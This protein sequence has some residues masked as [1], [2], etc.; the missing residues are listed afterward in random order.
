MLGADEFGFATAPLIAIGCL[1]MRKCHLNTCPVGIATQNPTLRKRFIGTPEHAINYLFF[2]AEEVRK[3]MAKLGFTKFNELIGKSQC[4]TQ[5]NKHNGLSLKPLLARAIP[6]KDDAT[7]NCTR[8]NHPIEKVLDRKLIRE[9]QPALK[10]KKRVNITT[11]ISNID[12]STGAMLSGEL[13]KIHNHKGLPADTINVELR[14]TAGQSFGA[15]LANGITFRLTGEGNDYVGKGL[16]GG[17]II[18]APESDFRPRHQNVIVGN[19]VLYGA[20]EGELYA[21]GLA[22]ERFAVRNSGAIAVVEGVGDHCCEYMT[23]GIV[24]AM[25]EYGRNFAAGMSGGIAY[26]Y[27]PQNTSRNTSKDTS[28]NKGFPISKVV[29]V[30]P[31][32]SF[33]EPQHKPQNEPEYKGLT[34]E[35]L[36]Y[37]DLTY[38]PLN[39]HQWRVKT[40]LQR[41]HYFTASPLAKELLENW[42]NTKNDFVVLTPPEFR[43]ALLSKN[44]NKNLKKS[45]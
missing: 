26:V 8:Q 28:Q 34:Y 35:D 27:K 31:L 45:A 6:A 20:L 29:E 22:G 40:L 44:L 33:D 24:L 41:H 18:I 43:N 5:K 10:H 36:T 32:M 30:M 21:S 37:E 16:C 15:F 42:E 11:A 38:D 23:G 1:M 4:L 7:Y 2:V 14:G 19:T 39:H 17:K 13:A 12:R 3:I 9:S 25:G